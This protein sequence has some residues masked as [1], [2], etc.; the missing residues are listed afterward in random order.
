[1]P[2]NPTINLIDVDGVARAIPA[3]EAQYYL[4][5]GWRADTAADV[6]NRT[7]DAANQ[8][9]YG[10]ASGAIRAGLAGALRGGTF[11]LSD[12]AARALGGEDATR[13]L[14]G[15]RE[16]NAAA[17]TIGEIGGALL[18]GG[19]ASLA[20]RAGARVAGTGGGALAQIGRAAVSGATEGAIMGAGSGVSAAALSAE[21]LDAE[22]LA[23]VM[24]SH[25]LLGAATGGIAGGAAKGIERG[26][27]RAKGAIDDVVARGD[28]VNAAAGVDDLAGLDRRGLK[29]AREQE[30]E[31]LAAEQVGQRSGS[32]DDVLAYRTKVQDGNPWLAIPDGQE[33]KVITTSNNSIRRALDD[34]RGLRKDPRSL[35]KPLRMQEQ[36]LESAVGRRAELAAKLERVNAKIAKDLDAT[37]RDLPAD[38]VEVEITGR[39]ARR[40]SSFSGAK[41]GKD[42]TVK[43][44]RSAAGDFLEAL[45]NGE[46]RGA[47]DRALDSLDGLIK[48]NRELQGKIERSITPRAELVSDRIRAIDSA[49]LA[50]QTPAPAQGLGG[51]LGDSAATYAL[52]ALAGVPGLGA[53]VAAGRAIAP[54]VKRLAREKTAVAA[55][56][57]KAVG[58]FLDASKRAP[59]SAPVLASKVLGGLSYAASS[60]SASRSARRPAEAPRHSLADAYRA[61]SAELRT[62]TQPTPAGPVMQQAARAQVAERLA[63]IRALDPLLYD[64]MEAAAARRIEFLA[65]KLPTRP[66]QAGPQIGPDMWAPSDMEIRKFARYAAAVEDPAAVVERLADGSVT[67]EDAEAMRAVYPEMFAD[68]QQQI[69][70]ALP[71]LRATLPYERR[72]AL[73]IFTGI[74][75]DP[76]MD[77]RVLSQLQATYRQEPN[78]GGGS[79]AP[80]PQPAFG[81]LKKSVEQPTPAQ[82]RGTR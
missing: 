3:D 81:S 42:A 32:V 37:L 7:V 54:L 45:R 59:V 82:R 47:S 8:E 21:P 75:V 80:R 46:V 63:P 41:V 64:R 60:T 50:L 5:R 2:D 71:E 28:S 62:L 58:A 77:P 39:A 76:T 52:G 18:P 35:L 25:I 49:D 74:P 27:A 23:S 19:A 48:A 40:Y 9:M 43:L 79:H 17:S 57:S 12:V 38:A 13:D 72:L 70:T 20:G 44:E 34:V 31:R 61:R 51:V 4:D 55:R 26:L 30:V 36:A 16:Q 15:L 56:A 53:A 1:M 65:G 78:T 73:S 24:G 6:A 22:Q 14:R 66:D 33:A 67:P 29:V 68:I 69:V 11:G 10:G